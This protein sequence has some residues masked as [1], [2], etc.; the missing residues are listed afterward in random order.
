MFCVPQKKEGREEQRPANHTEKQTN[1]PLPTQKY[2]HPSTHTH[3]H[4]HTHTHT[5]II[6]KKGKLTY[7]HIPTPTINTNHTHYTALT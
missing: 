4:S 5:I 3:A 6:M 7:A 1:D 2:T